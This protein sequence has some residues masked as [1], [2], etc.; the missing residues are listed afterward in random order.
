MSGQWAT[1]WPAPAKINLFLHITGRRDD[2]YHLL[3]TVFQ[4]LDYG[5]QLWFSLRNDAK[6]C[7]VTDV[8]GVA[9][10]DDLVVRAALSLQQATS[11][12]L[13][14]DI[15]IEKNLPMGG[16]LGGGSSDAA[17][18]LVALNQL[19][20]LG[21][22]IDQL[23][24]L[25]L[26]LGADVPVFVRGFAAWAEG[27]GEKLTPIE[28]PEPW[29]LVIHPQCHVSTAELFSDSD[30]TRDKQSLNISAF[31]AGHVTNVFE[32]VVRKYHPQVDKALNWLSKFGEAKMSG[33]GA[34]IFAAFANKK[35]AQAVLQL[36]PNEWRGFI[37]KGMNQSSLIERLT[38]ELE[39]SS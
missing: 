39:Q 26:T 6:V 28:L 32:P 38:I 13:G 7:R 2:G 23:A 29:F 37:A 33:S 34:C 15:K 16:G 20:G 19:W 30:L 9:E 5:D 11:S 18:V 35:E 1:A 21:L 12:T 27:V 22:S 24:T 17:T 8:I 36:L 14:V 25:G 10:A 31:L 3:Q 4:F